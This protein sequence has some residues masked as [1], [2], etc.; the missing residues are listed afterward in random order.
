MSIVV[1]TSILAKSF[2]RPESPRWVCRLQLLL[3]LASAVILGSKSRGTRDHILLP[4]IWNSPNLEGQVPVFLSPG[5]G[6]PNYTPTHWVPFSSPPTTRRATASTRGLNSPTNYFFITIFHEPNRKHRFQQGVFTDPLFRK[7]LHNSV[8]LLLRAC[9]LRALPCNG[10]CLQ[11]DYLAT[12]LYATICAGQCI[13]L[14]YS[15]KVCIGHGDVCNL[16]RLI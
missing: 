3:T 12:G 10:R 5:T 4:Q 1:G 16:V 15:W 7:G 8:L 13:P 6:W 9:M 14:R 11:R 2:T